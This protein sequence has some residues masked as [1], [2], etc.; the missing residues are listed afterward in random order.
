MSDL[1][2]DP[3]A[4]LWSIM[5]RARNGVVSVVRD[6]TLDQ[7]TK[8]YEHLDP[9]Y[10]RVIEAPRNGS[11]SY[12]VPT[13]PG[14]IEQREVFGPYGWSPD[15]LR[16]LRWPKVFYF[17]PPTSPSVSEGPAVT[18]AVTADLSARIERARNRR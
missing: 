16:D 5:T 6:L 18:T 11:Y 4:P 9:M 10:G 12:D 7:A 13:G 14:V 15:S 3:N 17:D 2:Y 8:V 1:P